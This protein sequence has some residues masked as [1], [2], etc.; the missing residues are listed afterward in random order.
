MFCFVYS[1]LISWII[2]FFPKATLFFFS[3]MWVH[4]AI[5]GTFLKI[6]TKTKK[7]S[8]LKNSRV[9][10][11]N[12]FN[13]FNL[14]YKIF[15][16]N[17]HKI[18]VVFNRYSFFGWNWKVFFFSL[19]FSSIFGVFLLNLTIK[20][21]PQ[22]Y[23]SKYLY[24]FTLI[25][26]FPFILRA[27]FIAPT[28]IS[29]FYPNLEHYYYNSS[30]SFVYTKFYKFPL[31]LFNYLFNQYSLVIIIHSHL[32]YLINFLMILNGVP[33]VFRYLNTRIDSTVD[34]KKN[35]YKHSQR[36]LLHSSLTISLGSHFPHFSFHLFFI[37]L[38]LFFYF[39]FLIQPYQLIQSPKDYL[40]K[41]NFW[42]SHSFVDQ[43]FS[44]LFL[45][46]KVCLK[47]D[48]FSLLFTQ[49]LLN[50]TF[51]NM[52]NFTVYVEILTTVYIKYFR[53]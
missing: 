18:N 10:K 34:T 17:G 2:Y 33:T 4:Q 36:N 51:F 3:T 20:I 42:N 53:F 15:R 21:I 12:I 1:I 23:L 24:T 49:D 9:K 45:K 7:R 50:L 27:S 44:D 52:I 47:P 28:C 6:N 29:N 8:K 14:F 32:T 38:V 37:F 16:L 25:L 40:F 5:N 43:H 46:D 39:L 11:R 35:Q 22:F 41:N 13:F 31:T 30:Y 48:T 26:A 19:F